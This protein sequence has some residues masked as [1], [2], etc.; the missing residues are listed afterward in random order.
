MVRGHAAHRRRCVRQN[1][2]NDRKRS[3][4]LTPRGLMGA[5]AGEKLRRVGPLPF[6][7]LSHVPWRILQ[8]DRTHVRIACLRRQSCDNASERMT[9]DQG[10][11]CDSR[12]RSHC[13]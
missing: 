8:V 9:N 2:E 3:V 12:E 11:A 1:I 13:V 6:G 7:R 5:D 4:V 10:R